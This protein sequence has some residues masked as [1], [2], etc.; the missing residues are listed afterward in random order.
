[1]RNMT[2]F[3]GGVGFHEIPRRANGTPL[4][5]VDELGQYRSHGCVRLAPE[6]AAY[7]YSWAEVGTPVVVLA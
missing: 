2:R 3:T 1:M 4:Q 5:T 7:L 6:D